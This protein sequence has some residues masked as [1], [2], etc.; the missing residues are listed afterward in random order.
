MLYSILM[1][2]IYLGLVGPIASGKGVLADY[3][4]SHGF[5]YVSLS[6]QVR[7][8]LTSRGMEINRK[9]LMD[10]GD[11]MRKLYG[12]GYW[13]DRA[14]SSVSNPCHNIVFDSIRNPGEI[15]QFRCIPKFKIIG[16]DAPVE[17]R[18]IWYLDRAKQRGEDDPDMSAFIQV[19]IRDRGVG[20]EKYG[21]QVDE[22]LKMSDVI[23]KNDYGK[24]EIINE[25]NKYLKTE[26]NFDP[27]I[28]RKHKE[29]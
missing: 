8:E 20:Q 3:L 12:N 23:F 16:V 17:K 27:E 4:K 22:C 24:E 7:Q 13:A 9:N 10:I 25:L 18:L 21:Q 2:P 6:D 5:E 1:S 19:S 11:E 29:K 28:H 14:M 26:F 15:M